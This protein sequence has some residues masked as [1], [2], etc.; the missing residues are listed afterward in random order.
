MKAIDINTALIEGY[1]KLLESLSPSSKLDL[2][3]KQTLSVKAET[4]DKKK[5]FY[6][7]FGAWESKLTADEIIDDIRNI[8]TF[9]RKIEKF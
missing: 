3:S 6:K 9:N 1:L 8:R 7:A 4:T 2:I 5:Y